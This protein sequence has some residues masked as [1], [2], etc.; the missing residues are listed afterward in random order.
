MILIRRFLGPWRQPAFP[1][2]LLATLTGPWVGLDVAVPMDPKPCTRLLAESKNGIKPSVKRWLEAGNHVIVLRHTE[3]GP[4]SKKAS[5]L[6]LKTGCLQSSEVLTELGQRQAMAIGKALRPY[7]VA[8][9]ASPACRT[10]QTAEVAFG[11]GGYEILEPLYWTHAAQMED[12]KV[13]GEI[14]EWNR[15]RAK[16]VVARTNVVL[17]THDTNLN[18]AGVGYLKARGCDKTPSQCNMGLAAIFDLKD[19]RLKGCLLPEDWERL[20]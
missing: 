10:L 4:K 7:V 8:V 19:K 11:K 13:L 15:L 14:E 2:W 20:D 1:I 16:L 9:Y 12:L 6:S 18:N 5:G 17:I 3:K